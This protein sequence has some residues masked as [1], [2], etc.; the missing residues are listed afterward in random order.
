MYSDKQQPLHH[1][2]SSHL[3]RH[4][5]SNVWPPQLLWTVDVQNWAVCPMPKH[6]EDP[7]KSSALPSQTQIS[8]CCSSHEAVYIGF[9]A[10]A[11]EVRHRDGAFSIRYKVNGPMTG[12]GTRLTCCYQGATVLYSVCPLY[13]S[14]P[15]DADTVT[16][17]PEATNLA[18]VIQTAGV[19]KCNIPA[20]CL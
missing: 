8:A 9:A 6:S 16:F 15:A 10:P 5:I 17:A 20:T 2:F 19:N 1:K 14:V 3:R 11:A 12:L 13:Q 18:V 7:A 4:W